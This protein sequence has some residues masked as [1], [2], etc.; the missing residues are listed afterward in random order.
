MT[1][2]ALDFGAVPVMYCC[3]HVDA[4]ARY[5]HCPTCGFQIIDHGCALARFTDPAHVAAGPDFDTSDF[6]CPGCR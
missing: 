1:T 3:G 6:A 2:P 4:G 5:Q